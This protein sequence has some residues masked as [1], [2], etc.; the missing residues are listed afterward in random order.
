MFWCRSSGVAKASPTFVP[1][2]GN[3]AC[4]V[5]CHLG[6]VLLPVVRP[7]GAGHQ[8]A[9][10]PNDCGEHARLNRTCWRQV[11]DIRGSADPPLHAFTFND[12]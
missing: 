12:L 7:N 8:R 10:R 11:D 2:L 5:R 9:D 3:S 6:R 1:V 4:Y